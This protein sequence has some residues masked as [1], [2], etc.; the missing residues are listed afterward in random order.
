MEKKLHKFVIDTLKFEFGDDEVEPWWYTGVA[1][2]VRK[3]ATLRHEEE[4]G[5]GKKENYLDLIDLRAIALNNWTLFQ[6][7][8]AFGKSGNKE[9]RTDWIHKLN[10]S[11]KVVMHGAKQQTISFEQLAQLREYE[12][13]L[14]EKLNHRQDGAEG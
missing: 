13:A 11:R 8:L 3:K 12:Q 1:E 7:S 10:E 5:K 4:K 2:S 9:V 14:N 6:D